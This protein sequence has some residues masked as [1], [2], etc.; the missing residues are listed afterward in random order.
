MTCRDPPWPWLASLLFLFFRSFLLFASLLLGRFYTQ[1]HLPGY[2]FVWCVFSPLFLWFFDPYFSFCCSIFPVKGVHTGYESTIKYHILLWSPAFL[3]LVFACDPPGWAGRV[4]NGRFVLGYF[5]FF[6]SLSCP[7]FV[8]FICLFHLSVSLRSST[9]G[10]LRKGD[11]LSYS[12]L[13][14]YPGES[15]R[16]DVFNNGKPTPRNG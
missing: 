14:S 1:S 6:L 16:S 2:G 13:R 11:L 15:T 10:T 3:H 4:I 7:F 12:R 5:G 8:Y 9:L